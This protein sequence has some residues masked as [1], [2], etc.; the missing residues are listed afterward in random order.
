MSRRSNLLAFLSGA[1]APV[2]LGVV[3]II[4]AGAA[5]AASCT[6]PGAPS[7]TQTKCLTA[8]AIPGN[9]LTSF[10]ISW[11]NPD[12]G[13]YYLAD[14]SNK[15][16]DVIDTAHLAFSRT[17]GTDKPFTGVVLN[18]AGT[19]VD[20]NHSGP[21]GVVSHGRWLYVGDGN[22]TLHVI[23]LNEPSAGSVTKQ[24]IAT[25]GTKR[26]DEMALTTDGTL[27]L[28]ANNADDPAFATLFVANGDASVSG[29]TVIKQIFV[30]PS[31]L[32]TGFGLSLEQPAWDPQTQRF[33]TSIPV[34]ANN[35]PGC[36]YGQLAGAITCSGG[37]L[38][39]DPLVPTATQ[40]AYD[41]VN[42]VGVIPLN[43][44]GPN[45]ATVGVNDNLLLGCTPA[46][47]PGSTTTLVINA[48]TRNYAQV[49]GITGA[50]EVFFNGGDNRY[51]TG[52]SG[53]IKAAGSTLARG[54]VL[55]VIDGTSVLVETI[56][57]SSGSHSVAAD[58]KHN[59]IFVP[60]TYTS[61]PTAI[62]LGD[63]NFTGAANASTTVGQLI[64]GGTTGCIAVYK[65]GPSAGGGS[66]VQPT[67]TVQIMDNVT[68]SQTTLA[69]G[70]SFTFL[71]TG[72]APFSLVFASEPG[73]S[74]T[75]GYTDANGTFRLNGFAGADVVG[76]Y[77]QTWT[78]GGVVAKP[79]P[80]QFTITPK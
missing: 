37:L 46:N 21:D 44:C 7:N 17:V 25:G 23:D 10:D 58:S 50:D 14:R 30:D 2:V 32:P 18:A 4:T 76:S 8:I 64:C 68:G 60:Q 55:G 78:I 33:Y 38:V 57:I 39:T 15:G 5:V 20:N 43:S 41:P 19:A 66:G 12:R 22:S 1:S 74:A 29:V 72:A 27:L 11:V 9:P 63:Q 59:L 70:D 67:P 35:P 48:K 13:E 16:V 6:G 3:S 61:A 73:W 53:A 51:Y 47:L 45:G 65:G 77:Q 40:G 49:G 75:L 28:A 36:N 80:L 56:P 62:P 42:N 69:V 26:L 79:T 71:V 52:S 34:I 24:V 54:S 31:I